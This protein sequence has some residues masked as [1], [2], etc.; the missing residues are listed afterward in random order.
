MYTDNNPDL[1]RFKA[2]G[3]KL[4]VAQGGNDGLEIPGAI[5]DYYETVER[6]MGG[7]EPIGAQT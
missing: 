3:G 7:R 6:T 4:I 5:F 1:R 2:A